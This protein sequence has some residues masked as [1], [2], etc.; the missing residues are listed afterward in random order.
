[1]VLLAFEVECCTEHAHDDNSKDDTWNWQHLPLI[2][3]FTLCEF[4]NRIRNDVSK[5][6]QRQSPSLYLWAEKSLLKQTFLLLLSWIRKHEEVIMIQFLAMIYRIAGC[7]FFCIC[8]AK[9]E[10]HR[11]HNYKSYY[12]KTFY[13]FSTYLGHTFWNYGGVQDNLPEKQICVHQNFPVPGMTSNLLYDT[14]FT[15]V[16]DLV[17]G[18]QFTIHLPI[19]MIDITNERELQYACKYLFIHSVT[20]SK[21]MIWHNNF[22]LYY[23]GLIASYYIKTRIHK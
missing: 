23:Q 1:M 14:D 9:S 10:I 22:N 11:Y 15:V 20:S 16:Y 4:K 21:S 3:F 6:Q 8:M 19:T 17:L 2:N 12:Q 13:D 5:T 7:F 18:C